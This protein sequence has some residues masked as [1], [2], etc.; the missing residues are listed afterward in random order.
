MI[1][2]CILLL[3]PTIDDVFPQ[4]ISWVDASVREFGVGGQRGWFFEGTTREIK[5]GN[6]SV[7][8][9]LDFVGESEEGQVALFIINNESVI[10]ERRD[11][12][13]AGEVWVFVHEI[14]LRR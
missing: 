12:T 10:A 8:V 13:R 6:D 1:L 7:N 9:S 11:D 3:C 5:I 14:Y 2:F 4:D